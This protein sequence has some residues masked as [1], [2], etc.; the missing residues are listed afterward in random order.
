M[1]LAQS[2]KDVKKAEAEIILINKQH[3]FKMNY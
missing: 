2:K 1:E 3:K